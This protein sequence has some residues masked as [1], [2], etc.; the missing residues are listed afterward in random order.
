LTTLATFLAF[1]EPERRNGLTGSSSDRS[2]PSSSLSSLTAQSKLNVEGLPVGWTMQVS[3][4]GQR[5]YL[6][7]FIF[8]VTY[9]WAQQAEFL[10]LAGFFCLV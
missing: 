8:I 6:Q 3:E 9:E 5:T 10:V 2:L 7:N 4:K 1:S